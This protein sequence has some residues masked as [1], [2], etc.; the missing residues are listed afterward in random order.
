MSL[1]APSV[2]FDGDQ[3]TALMKAIQKNDIVNALIAQGAT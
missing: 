1:P 3:R 2:S